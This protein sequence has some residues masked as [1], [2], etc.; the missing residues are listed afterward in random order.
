MSVA[1]LI[2]GRG[3]NLKAILDANLPVSLVVSNRRNAL[4]LR[5][6]EARAIKTAIVADDDYPSPAEADKQLAACLLKE[7]P[8][9]VALAGFMRV[10]GADIV[11]EF[12][13]KMINIHP[14]LLPNLRG[15]NTHRRAL[16]SAAAEHGCTVHWVSEAVDEGEIIAQAKV[17]V[18][19]DDTEQTLAA[20]VLK[21]EHSLYPQVIAKLLQNR[22]GV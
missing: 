4:G 9:V 11:R 22:D 5:H 10:L 15:L 17:P 16:E 8:K 21:A 19:Q 20:R 7:S 13:G 2:S 6:A 3:S 12:A 14:S 18:M 1:V